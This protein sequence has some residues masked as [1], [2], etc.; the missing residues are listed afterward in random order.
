MREARE[1]G[2]GKTE[3]KR[4]GEREEKGDEGKGRRRREEGE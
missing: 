3:M 2:E 1:W 4:E